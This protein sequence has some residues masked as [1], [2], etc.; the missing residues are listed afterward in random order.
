[1][2]PYYEHAGITIYHGDCREIIPTLGAITAVVMDPPYCSGGF[3]EAGKRAA[4]GMGLRSETIRD[5][6][7]FTN[8]NMTTAG[9]AWLLS[10]VAGW[11]CR[12]LVDGG[13]L[14]AFTDWRMVPN[15]APA[16]EGSGLRYQNL[17]VWK[18][19]N[20]GLGTGF[21]P[22]HELAMHF[23]KGT[24]TYYALNSGNVIDSARV[25]SVDRHHQTE[26]PVELM[27]EIIRVVC[28]S[29][30]VVLDPFMGSGSTLCA[31][32][33]LGIKA[34]GVEL[35]EKYCEIAARRL[36]QEVFQFD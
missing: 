26:K 14:T 36:E 2:K 15:L 10:F 30:G 4:K 9:A 12:N 11:C 35:S 32:K 13:T 8:D 3:N 16:I 17:L 21:K 1:M 24:P 31:A 20:F 19:P 27:Q 25:N 23:S 22:Q 7:W 33:T 6:G 34:I 18:K 5:V 28:D 29:S